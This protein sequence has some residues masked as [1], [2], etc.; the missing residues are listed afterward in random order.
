MKDGALAAS[1][2]RKLDKGG[3]SLKEAAGAPNHLGQ[4][5]PVSCLHLVE[6]V[7]TILSSESLPSWPSVWRSAEGRAVWSWLER[8]APAFAH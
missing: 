3:Y 5:E 2:A 7:L 1:S 8:G 6:E 4:N